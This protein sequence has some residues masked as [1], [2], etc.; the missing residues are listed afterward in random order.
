MRKYLLCFSFIILLSF[1]GCSAAV[2]DD[3]TT[4]RHSIS[5][6]HIYTFDITPTTPAPPHT[7]VSESSSGERQEATAKAEIQ[8]TTADQSADPDAS[9]AEET[10][11]FYVLNKRSKKIHLPSCP[12]VKTIAEKNYA[13]TDR[14]ADAVA[15]GF[16]PCKLCNP[17]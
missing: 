11:A 6:A 14:Y 10:P 7:D 4:S 17:Q 16:V 1:Y 8:A 3:T 15:N 2:N 12:S 5:Y 13:V 9:Q